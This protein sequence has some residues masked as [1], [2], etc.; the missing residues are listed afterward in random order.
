[1]SRDLRNDAA[2][3]IDWARLVEVRERRKKLALQAMLA[4]R[5]EAERSRAAAQREADERERRVAAKLAHWQA[6]RGA[7]ASG[8]FNA[9]QLGTAT[10]WSGVL[11][12]GIAQQDG[13]LRDAHAALAE[14]E[15]VLDT[16]R[17]ALRRAASGVQKVV[18]LQQ[19]EHERAGRIA[20]ARLDALNEDLAATRWS[21]RRPA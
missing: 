1:M 15:R 2:S 19:R 17:A 6:A 9:A 3:G 7:L 18:T 12:A 8:A 21:A 5:R 13:T 20:E 11:D 14:R 16:S 4:D 10:A